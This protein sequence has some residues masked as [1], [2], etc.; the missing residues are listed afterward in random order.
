[1]DFLMFIWYVWEFKSMWRK[2]N[3]NLSASISIFL[4]IFFK[5]FFSVTVQ[6]IYAQ[7]IFFKI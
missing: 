5:D 1:M 6:I 3:W 2:N 4:S 7:N